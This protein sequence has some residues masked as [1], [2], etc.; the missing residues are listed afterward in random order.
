MNQLLSDDVDHHFRGYLHIYAKVKSEDGSEFT[1]FDD[2]TP[3]SREKVDIEFTFDTRRHF[4]PGLPFVGKV[5]FDLDSKFFDFAL[6]ATFS[7]G[8]TSL[9]T[10]AKCDSPHALQ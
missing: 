10:F 1:A 6:T 4:K 7:A 3:V 9:D 5:S 2:S 8:F